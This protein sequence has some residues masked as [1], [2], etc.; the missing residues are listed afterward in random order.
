[1]EG[2]KGNGFVCHCACSQYYGHFW[3]NLL[4][5]YV[6]Q[7]RTS[8][9]KITITEL[10]RR[11]NGRGPFYFDPLITHHTHYKHGGSANILL[12]LYLQAIS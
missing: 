8:R 4:F 2:R 3:P 1:M 5:D 12:L 11:A 6:K 10:R 9:E 7:A